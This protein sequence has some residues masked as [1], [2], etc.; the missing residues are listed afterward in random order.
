MPKLEILK[1]KKVKEILSQIKEQWGA[2]FKSD[3]VFLLSPKRKIYAISREIEKIN[4]SDLKI[5]SVGVYF[6]NIKDKLRLSIEA[7]QLVGP[8]ATKNILVLND[9]EARQWLMGE[10]LIKK[11][12]N[13]NGYVLV[14]Y[15]NDFLGCARITEKK[16]LNFYPKARRIQA[17]L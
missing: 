11:T 7:S 10:D 16:I 12:T 4:T 9:N 1:K 17:T 3:L 15:N 5:D 13:L 6:G 2:D 8:A 14:R